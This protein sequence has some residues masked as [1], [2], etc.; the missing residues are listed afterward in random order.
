[1][2]GVEKWYVDPEGNYV[3]KF[4]SPNEFAIPRFGVLRTGLI[5]LLIVNTTFFVF[6]ILA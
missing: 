6:S 2:G 3:R 5:L 1:M 4:M